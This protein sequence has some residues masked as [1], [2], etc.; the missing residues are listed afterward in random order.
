MKHTAQGPHWATAVML[1]LLLALASSAA[2]TSADDGDRLQPDCVGGKRLGIVPLHEAVRHNCVPEVEAL[3]DAGFDVNAG[4]TKPLHVAARH[5]SV[6]AAV[7]LIDRGAEIDARDREGRTPLHIAMLEESAG[8]AALLIDRGADVDAR[9]GEGRTP[10]CIAAWEGFAEAATAL[11]DH[12]AEIDAKDGEGRTPLRIAARE[13]SAE[14]AAVLVDRGADVDAR[15]RD[16]QTPLHDAAY[17]ESAAVAALLIEQGAEVDARDNLGWT[18]LHLALG[19]HAPMSMFPRPPGRQTAY[20]LL[21]HGADV[22]A[23]TAVMGWTPLHLAAYLGGS[24]VRQVSGGWVGDGFGHGPDVYELVQTLIDRGADV[25]ARAHAG[26]W[27]PLRVAKKSDGWRQNGETGECVVDRQHCPLLPTKYKPGDGANWSI[28]VQNAL[29]AAGGRDEGCDDGPAVPS[30][31]LGSEWIPE[32]EQERR[33]AGVAAPCQFDMPLAAAGAMSRGRQI[34][35]GS[36]TA[37]GADERLL[38]QF[39]CVTDVGGEHVTILQDRHGA[40]RPIMSSGYGWMD[41]QGLC[42]DRLTNAHTAVFKRTQEERWSEGEWFQYFHYDEAA[43]TLVRLS[44]T[45]SRP[46][47]GKDEPCRWRE[48]M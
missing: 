32:E 27:T 41:Y 9:D 34:A 8:V 22:S 36:F 20:L 29:R 43:G 11:I 25:N 14:V 31:T 3:L 24:E 37:P 38:T 39:C 13:G 46:P 5:Q 19:V 16:G 4:T 21:E 42:L 33:R 7:M 35:R 30:Y 6:A 28:V 44:E 12:G 15:D 1:P 23:A 10:L 26:G 40:I 48:E 2:S 18:P 17:H 47:L 45:H